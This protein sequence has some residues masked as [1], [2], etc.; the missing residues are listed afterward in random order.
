MWVAVRRGGPRLLR[1]GAADATGQERHAGHPR[2][3]GG[4]DGPHRVSHRHSLVRG[5]ARLFQGPRDQ[6]GR[7]SARGDVVLAGGVRDDVVGVEGGPHHGEFPAVGRG[8]QDDPEAP[9]GHRAQQVGGTV[10][11]AGVGP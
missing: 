10:Q 9:G 5:Y 1:F 3:P 11:R 8:G 6:V 7:A 4:L 2:L